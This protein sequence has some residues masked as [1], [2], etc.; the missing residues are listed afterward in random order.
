MGADSAGG[1]STGGANG[2][3]F[4]AEKSLSGCVL[5]TSLDTAPD[6]LALFCEL[7]EGF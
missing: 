4:I 7:D 2:S 5:T 1:N 3:V 6:D